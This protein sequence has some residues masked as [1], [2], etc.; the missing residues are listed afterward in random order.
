M[1]GR[2]HGARAAKSIIPWVNS[3]RNRV[4][5]HLGRDLSHFRFPDCRLEP[6]FDVAPSKIVTMVRLNQKVVNTPAYFLGGDWA[7]LSIPLANYCKTNVRYVSCRQV[8]VDRKDIRDTPEFEYLRNLLKKRAKV[9][10]VTT[11]NEIERYL[12]RIQ[13]MYFAVERNGK[14]ST[15]KDL[16]GPR[17]GEEISFAISSDLELVKV[18]GGHHRFAAAVALGLSVIPGQVR[19]IHSD[20]IPYIQR[21]HDSS[22]AGIRDFIRSVV[23]R[24]QYSL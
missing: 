3:L 20:C 15:Q 21:H 19:K 17:F 2:A 8:L 1:V 10:N 5:G 7:S 6:S 22:V 11:E 24:Y 13:D 9:R 12:L 16:C 4:S 14:I 23:K 18:D